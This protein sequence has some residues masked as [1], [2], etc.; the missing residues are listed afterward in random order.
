MQIIH[1]LSSTA[2]CKSAREIVDGQVFSLL[3]QAHMCG[4]SVGCI[5]YIMCEKFR[6][7]MLTWGVMGSI[8]SAVGRGRWVLSDSCW[9]CLWD[10]LGHFGRPIGQGRCHRAVGGLVVAEVAEVD[11]HVFKWTRWPVYRATTIRQSWIRSLG[12]TAARVASK[13]PQRRVV[14]FC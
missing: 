5:N 2:L 10:R 13:C 8:V 7:K 9:C 12:W 3:S 1:V 11:A 4:F 14:H 6:V